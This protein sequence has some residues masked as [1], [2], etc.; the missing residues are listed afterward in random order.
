[1][2]SPDP[3]SYCSAGFIGKNILLIASHCLC[4]NMFET[5]KYIEYKDNVYFQVKD[6]YYH[7]GKYCK[8]SSSNP[9]E[10]VR[11]LAVLTISTLNHAVSRVNV[12][13]KNDPTKDLDLS[14]GFFGVGFGG[15]EYIPN[16][17]S[18]SDKP[19]IG[20]IDTSLLNFSNVIFMSSNTKASPFYGDSG[21]PIFAYDKQGNLLQV[22]VDSAFFSPGDGIFA[23]TYNSTKY[24][25]DLSEYYIPNGM[26]LEDIFSDIDPDG[27]GISKD[28]DNCPD[29]ANEDQSDFDGDGFGDA[30]DNCAGSSCEEIWGDVSKCENIDQKDSDKDGIGDVCDLCPESS[31]LNQDDQDKDRVG[32]VCDLC[33]TLPNPFQPCS[34]DSDCTAPDGNK[35]FCVLPDCQGVDCS[36]IKGHC[37]VQTSGDLDGDG[38]GDLCDN[39]PTLKNKGGQGQ[40][41]DGDGVG[42]A[43]DNCPTTPN[44]KANCSFGPCVDPQGQQHPCIP[45][46]DGFGYCAIQLDDQ[47]GDGIGDSCDNCTSVAD[48]TVQVN[49]NDFAE[50]REE[51]FT[52]A[53]VPPKNDACEPLPVLNARQLGTADKPDDV[54]FLPVLPGTSPQNDTIFASAGALG[55]GA[56]VLGNPVTSVNRT[57]EFRHCSC[58]EDGII[59]NKKDCWESMC[60]Q[61]PAQV[62]FSDEDPALT[63]QKVTVG[64]F[65]SNKKE[66]FKPTFNPKFLLNFANEIDCT[67]DAW[68]HANTSDE[69]CRF[70]RVH[71]FRWN[72]QSDISRPAGT[73]PLP[74]GSYDNQGKTVGLFWSHT[75]RNS[76]VDTL[77]E[78]DQLS[79]GRLRDNY[80]YVRTPSGIGVNV[81]PPPNEAIP[82]L[83]QGCY[84][85]FR[86]D[87]LWETSLLP[88]DILTNLGKHAL[89]IPSLPDLVTAVSVERVGPL[90]VTRAFPGTNLEEY[91]TGNFSWLSPVEPGFP[92]RTSP[93]TPQALGVPR[94]VVPGVTQLLPVTISNGGFSLGVRRVVETLPAPLNQASSPL[95]K[96]QTALTSGV[97]WVGVYSGIEQNAYLVGGQPGGAPGE[98]WEYNLSSQGWR[99]LFDAS[100]L[101]P[102]KVLA[103]TYDSDSGKLIVLDE[104]GGGWLKK[105]RLL[106]FN[107]RT[108]QVKQVLSIP[109]LGLFSSF[110]LVS[111][112]GSFWL[113]AGGKNHWKLFSFQ[114]SSSD[115]LTWTGLSA[116]QGQMLD[117]PFQASDGVYLPLRS[118]GKSW[119]EV[120]EPWG[121]LPFGGCSAL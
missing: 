47:D 10:H 62:D 76:A 90:D 115:K 94:T 49:S 120:I 13:T 103:A 32:D 11:D 44:P 45:A 112:E 16:G 26:F 21:G 84:M 83:F 20:E 105:A 15:F 25:P 111:R 27:D 46:P 3:R 29:I 102:A 65:D 36:S 18:V 114:L 81:P 14:A 9:Q 104:Q 66:T 54:A 117:G 39:C 28:L 118:K 33:P 108:G 35:H 72:Q 63:W 56:N 68:P 41:K 110:G 55:S 109:R 57:V 85:V 53:P 86:N 98:V 82:C 37:S 4:T 89:L 79:A 116:G 5:N 52:G 12:Y 74:V 71:L 88:K 70:G 42:D 64:R 23:P 67:T 75:L 77:S 78:R 91:A 50:L 96:S 17:G 40:D 95:A 101:Q 59:V 99:R 60:A 107:T 58:Y 7:P 87:W 24:N 100:S 2:K 22:A 80:E 92:S 119:L 34:K 69:A 38:V 61:N 97:N 43:C 31:S 51:A 30:C 93:S 1:M 73:F 8:P 113:V 6:V 106:V 121:P 48:A 19:S